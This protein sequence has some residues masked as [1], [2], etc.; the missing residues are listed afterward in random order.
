MLSQG[1]RRSSGSRPSGEVFAEVKAKVDCRKLIADDGSRENFGRYDRQH[2]INPEHPDD[3]PTMRIYQDGVMCAACGYR[4]DAIDVY[5]LW[6]PEAGKMDAA[7]ALLANPELTF[8]GTPEGEAGAVRQLRTLN[9]DDAVRYHLALASNPLAISG[10]MRMGFELRTIK[11]FRLGWARVLV[12]LPMGE[13]Y[14]TFADTEVRQDRAGKDVTYQWQDRYA[15]P[16]FEGKTLRQIIYRKSD[17]AQ[18]GGKTT[19]EKDAGAWLFGRDELEGK[20]IVVICAGWGDKLI[21]W[22]WGITA[23]CSTNGDGHWNDEWNED[24]GN[25]SRLYSVV[26]ADKAGVRLR[27]RISERLPWCRHVGLGFEEGSKMDVRDYKLAG[28]DGRDFIKMMRQADISASIRVLAK[29]G[30]NGA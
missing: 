17:D 14:S 8:E 4:G 22:Q 15:V 27:E 20:R 18:L 9:P 5:Q 30:G 10:L 19:M 13:D 24:L 28:H 7:R 2:C 1:L 11:Q 21:L 25:A 3:N 26:D 23:V 29:L 16:I 12:R 6:N